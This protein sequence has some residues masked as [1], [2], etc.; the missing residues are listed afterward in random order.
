MDYYWIPII[1]FLV[2]IFSDTGSSTWSPF[3]SDQ[4]KEICAHLTKTERRTA[5]KRGALWGLLLGIIPGMTGLILG[6]VVFRNALIGVIACLLILPIIA[7]VLKRK[8]FPYIVKSQQI[9]LASTEWVRSHD[10]KADDIKLYKWS[11]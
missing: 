8:W 10:I 7:L 6:I 11:K 1:L 9:Y 5:I 4:V 2:V 3:Q